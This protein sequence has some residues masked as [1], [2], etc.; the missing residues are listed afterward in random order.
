MRKQTLISP[1]G[2][3]PSMDSKLSIN[4]GP[5]QASPKSAEPLP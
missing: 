2:I 5:L 4:L 1:W 3:C